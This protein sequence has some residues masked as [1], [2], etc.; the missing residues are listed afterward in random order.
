MMKKEKLYVVRLFGLNNV[1]MD[2]SKP[3][4]FKEANKIWMEKTKDGTK[5]TKFSDIDYYK[6]FTAENYYV[7]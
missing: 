2:A 3:L 5:N 6:V 4:P 7:G 1:W